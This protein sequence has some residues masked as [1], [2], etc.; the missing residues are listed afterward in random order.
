MAGTTNAQVS[1]LKRVFD[2]TLS[3]GGAD[4]SNIATATGLF[5]NNTSLTFDILNNIL[6]YSDTQNVTN[7]CF[8]FAK[9]TSLTTIPNI[10]TTNVTNMSYMFAGCTSLTSMPLLNTS[11]VTNMSN[12]FNTCSRLTTIPLFNT[13]IVTNMS[14]MFA[15]ST[16]LSSIP[17]LNVSNVTNFNNTLLNCANLREI[18]ITNIK[19]N[20]RIS[21]STRFTRDALNE[22]IGN[23]VDVGSSRTLTI[24]ATNLAKLTADDIAVAT[25][26]GWTIA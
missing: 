16:D 1:T 15:S 17:A 9:C 10:D 14:N 19:A 18:H 25:A 7:M 23:L 20:F 13:S 21:Y 4:N 5:S 6:H 26:K 12:M 22:I 3:F 11:K 24:G 2:E 8:G